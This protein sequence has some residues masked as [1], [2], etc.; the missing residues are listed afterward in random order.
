MHATCHSGS[1][2]FRLSLLYLLSAFEVAEDTRLALHLNQSWAAD[3][4][5]NLARLVKPLTHIRDRSRS[6]AVE[7][8]I[9]KGL[10]RVLLR[11][12]V[13]IFGAVC[14]SGKPVGWG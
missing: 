11:A 5:C 9:E 1:I 2:P 4:V 3:F 10:R 14:A 13:E 7:A 6:H 8:L 12:D